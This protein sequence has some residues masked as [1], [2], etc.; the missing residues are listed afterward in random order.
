MSVTIVMSIRAPA[1]TERVLSMAPRFSL[2]ICNKLTAVESKSSI[3]SVYVNERVFDF[4]PCWAC[5]SNLGKG[6]YKGVSFI[7]ISINFLF[8]P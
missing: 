1:I 5:V 4:H 2:F 7:D 8:A 3:M 6:G